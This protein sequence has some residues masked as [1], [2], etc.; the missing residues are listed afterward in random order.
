M[1]EENLNEKVNIDGRTRIYRETVARLDAA[2]KLREQRLKSMKE[3]RFNGLYDD[4]SG[5]G[6]VVPQPVD[7]T[8]SEAMKVVEKYRA[9]REKKKTLMGTA[10]KESQ[11]TEEESIEIAGEILDEASDMMLRSWIRNHYPKADN[12]TFNKILS[13]MSR[14]YAKDPKG[15]THFGGFSKVA[16]DAKIKEQIEESNSVEN[17]VQMKGEK[18]VMDEAELSP[19]QKKYRAFFD[20]TLKKFGASSPAKMD[21]DKKKKFFAYIKANWKG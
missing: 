4:G 3:N 20:K 2:R 18:Y 13:A 1:S 6:A 7:Y 5:K 19:D 8:F 9:L 14:Q 17:A 15:Y 16:K 11:H 21:D 12:A 10:K